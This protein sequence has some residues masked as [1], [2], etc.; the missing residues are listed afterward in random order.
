MAD[1]NAVTT[2]KKDSPYPSSLTPPSILSQLSQALS[3]LATTID[4]PRVLVL[5]FLPLY[6][7]HQSL[8]TPLYPSTFLWSFVLY[9]TTGL[10]ITAGYHRLWAHTSCRACFPLRV[11]LALARAGAMEGS[12]RWWARDHRAHHRWTDTP[13]DPYSV[14]KGFWHAHMGW[15]LFR[16]GTKRVGRVDISDLDQD[17]VVMWQHRHFGLLSIACALVFPVAV[18]SAWGD[19][20]GAFVYAGILRLFFTHQ[21][22]FC[23]SSLAHWIGEATFEDRKTPR[24]HWITALFTFGEGYHNFH[25]T[26]PSDYRNGIAWW[27]YDP[28]KTVIRVWEWMGLAVDLKR[29]GDGE[30]VKSRILMEER[31]VE[32]LRKEV[33]ERKKGLVWG[34]GL[35]D[36]PIVEWDDFVER[37]NAKEEL[38][39]VVG[40]VHDVGA[41]V[42]QH[43]GGGGGALIKSFVGKDATAVFN[44]GVYDHGAPARNLLSTMRVAVLR[45]GGEVEVWKRDSGFVEAGPTAKIPILA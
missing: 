17:P 45:G 9:W 8:S 22:T 42:G 41:F 21:C 23:V 4:W 30:V 38:L 27:Q 10:G 37:V 15:L 18:G 12:I 6:G 36:L 16:D 39:V 20:W 1:H 40:V 24:D 28:T 31:R 14:T 32:G 43:P 34:P 11:F 44:G 19:P 26:F 2:S 25:H 3:D 29:F 33:E 13:R 7:L 35:K 5:I